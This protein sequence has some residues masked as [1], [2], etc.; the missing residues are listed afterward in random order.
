MTD[1]ALY[2]ADFPSEA[3]SLMPSYE[4]R[5]SWMR[6]SE[7][8]ANNPFW[9]TDGIDPM[10]IRQGA[11]GDCWFIAAASAL[12]EKPKRL[13]KLFLDRSGKISKNGIYGI[14]I[15]TLGVPHTVIIDDYLPL[16]YLV[17]DSGAVYT[18]VFSQVGRDQS[19]WG[20][21]LEKAFAKV[22]GNYGHMF[23]G[24]PRDGIRSLVGAPSLLYTHTSFNVEFIWS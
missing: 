21:I 3:M 1:D 23:S 9:G 12:S 14:N 16:Q 6:V 5:V 13:E 24:D 8:F 17:Q 18:T 10:D 22:Y 2:W 20:A 7:R 11:I 19:L 15:Y 4:S